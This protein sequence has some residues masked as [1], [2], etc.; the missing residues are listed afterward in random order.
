[1]TSEPVNIFEYTTDDISIS[2]KEYKR[3]MGVGNGKADTGLE[4]MIDECRAELC[5]VIKIR[6]C[7]R[8]CDVDASDENGVNLGFIH[9]DSRDLSKNLRVCRRAVVFAVTIGVEADRLISKYNAI[10]PSRAVAADAVASAA[11]E[12]ATER[13]CADLKI[14]YGNM[15]PRFSPGYGDFPLSYQPYICEFLDCGRKAG[16]RLTESFMLVPVKTTTAI[17]GIISDDL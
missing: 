10:S 14:K 8:L 13:L 3:Y 2:E 12:A 15:R 17:A 9:P 6:G 11:V 5:R 7:Y 4:R 1:M 16:I